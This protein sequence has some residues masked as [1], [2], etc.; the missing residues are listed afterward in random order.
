MMATLAC[1][2]TVVE[3]ETRDTRGP[4]QTK[5]TDHNRESLPEDDDIDDIDDADDDADAPYFS[6]LLSPST[7]SAGTP[8][9]GRGSLVCVVPMAFAVKI[10][11]LTLNM[12]ENDVDE[13]QQKKRRKTHKK[14]KNNNNNTSNGEG[15]EGK[16]DP[17][18]APKETSSDAFMRAYYQGIL[19]LRAIQEHTFTYNMESSHVQIVSGNWTRAQNLYHTNKGRNDP[20]GTTG[21]TGT[22]DTTESK[23]ESATQPASKALSTIVRTYLRV[24]C[25]DL[26]LAEGPSHWSPNRW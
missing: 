3:R 12:I 21:T 10:R 26:V 11:S 24:S 23:E 6:G 1:F 5:G 17:E 22:T 8:E 15:N 7:N 2:G 4:K 14:N 16:H 25:A 20:T 9:V 13:Q 18:A 19:R